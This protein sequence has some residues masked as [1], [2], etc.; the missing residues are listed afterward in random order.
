MESCSGPCRFK[1]EH[2]VNVDTGTSRGY[3]VPCVTAKNDV[4]ERRKVLLYLYGGAHVGGGAVYNLTMASNTASAMG[5][6]VYIPE[7][8]YAP[9]HTV[10]EATKDALDGWIYLTHERKIAPEDVLLFG[11]SSGGGLA[12]ALLQVCAREPLRLG[13]AAGAVL[14]GPWVEYTECT[15]SIS[16]NTVLDMIVTQRVY[17]CVR[18][19]LPAI[20]GGASEEHRKAASPLFQSMEG[21]P[22]VYLSCSNHEATRDEAYMLSERLSAAGVKHTFYT[23]DFMPHVWQ[24]FV[25]Q[26]VPEAVEDM[27]RVRAWAAGTLLAAERGCAAAAEVLQ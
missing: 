20:C 7:T 16:Q 17:D 11:F 13:R 1:S 2:I 12:L 4:L 15:A 10:M 27:A 14:I 22:P 5:L 23:R 8:R 18:P 25:E 6:D 19:I 3:Y 21:L 24:I 9:E 26:G